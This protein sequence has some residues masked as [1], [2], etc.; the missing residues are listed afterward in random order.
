[1]NEMIILLLWLIIYVTRNNILT[2]VKYVLI[3]LLN[4]LNVSLLVLVFVVH[5]DKRQ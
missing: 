2:C 1:M 4:L 3:N 5:R